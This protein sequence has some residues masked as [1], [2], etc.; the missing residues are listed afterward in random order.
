MKQY[1]TELRLIETYGALLS[2]KKL[3]YIQMHYFDDL[4]L[5]EIAQN[6]DISRA[7]VQDAIKSGLKELHEFENKLHLISHQD[8]R[9]KFIKQ[10]VKDSDII[11][12]YIELEL[13]DK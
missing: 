9:I 4:S 1:K 3:E 2:P 6:Y 11:M 13:G 10:N 12:K 7:A 8:A 5:S